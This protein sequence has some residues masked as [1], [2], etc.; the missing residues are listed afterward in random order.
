LL[1]IFREKLNLHGRI[2]KFAADN[3]FSVYVIHAPVVAAI[4]RLL[5]GVPWHPLVKFVT[6][7]GSATAASFALSAVVLSRIPGLRP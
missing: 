6:L 5:Y 7:T 1:V 2:S 3:A 4:A